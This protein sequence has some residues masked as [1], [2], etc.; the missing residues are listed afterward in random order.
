MYNLSD[1]TTPL[2]YN[3]PVVDYKIYTENNKPYYK[4]IRADGSPQLFLSFLSLLR[5]FDREDLEML[6]ELVKKSSSMEESKNS[7]WFSKGQELETV[8]VLWSAHYHIYFYTDDLASI[9]KISTYKVHSGSNAQQCGEPISW[10]NLIPT[11]INVMA[12]RLSL[13]KLPT[14]LNLDARGLR[15]DCSMVGSGC[16]E[17]KFVYSMVELVFQYSDEEDAKS[18]FYTLWWHV[19]AHRNDC[20]F[21]VASPRKRLGLCRSY[22]FLR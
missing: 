7:S 10:C 17:I 16:S 21:G 1:I 13:D 15:L 19:W 11:K 2:A 12:W 20:V 3:V 14:H 6:W 5:N 22:G 8:R 18:I 4:V 9:E